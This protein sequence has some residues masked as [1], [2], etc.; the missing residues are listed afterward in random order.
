MPGRCP[1]AHAE[2]AGWK[3]LEGEGRSPGRDWC[4]ESYQILGIGREQALGLAHEYG[5]VAFLQVE[6]DGVPELVLCEREMREG[7][8]R[9][10]R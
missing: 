2:A 8:I 5:Q 7:S 4:E 6:S 9:H 10:R 1:P 3:V